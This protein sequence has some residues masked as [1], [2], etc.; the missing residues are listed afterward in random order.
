MAQDFVKL[1][2][3]KQQDIKEKYKGA[4]SSMLKSRYNFKKGQIPKTFPEFLQRAK[5]EDN[6]QA[7]V[8]MWTP[9]SLKSLIASA[10]L[11]CRL[12]ETVSFRALV[13]HVTSAFFY[14]I[15]KTQDGMHRGDYFD[16]RHSIAAANLDVFVCKDEEARKYA[17]SRCRN[18]QR[19]ETLDEFIAS[20]GK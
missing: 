12:D 8:E 11:A 10:E 18:G 3:K 1:Q 19:V 2:L 15:L 16:T 14:K 6:L 5:A 20:L 13:Y 9:Q 4:W 7:L 17:S